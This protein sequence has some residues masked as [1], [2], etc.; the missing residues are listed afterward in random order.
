MQAF[1]RSI[2]HTV[3]H[4]LLILDAG[5]RVVVAN[6]SFYRTFGG[7][8]SLI[9]GC[10]LF[11]ID[12]GR[13]DHP[14]LRTLLVGVIPKDG[15]FR[16][17]EVEIDC[18]R[19]GRR[20]M[21]LDAHRVVRDEDGIPMVLLAIEDDTERRKA[22]DELYQL[23]TDLEHRIKT[24]EHKG[25]ELARFVETTR[26]QTLVESDRKIA[27]LE[28]KARDLADLVE[29]L[30]NQTQ[31]QSD[32][33]IALLVQK[34]RDLAVFV[35][36]VRN[37]TRSQAETEIA[38]LGQQAR[39]LAV[40]VEAVRELTLQHSDSQIAALGQSEKVTSRLNDELER[41]V[42]ERTR[43]LEAANRE[44]EAFCYSVSHDLRSPLRA[45]DG[46]SQELLQNYA[47]LLDEQGRHYLRRIRAGTQRM[48]QLID[49]LLRLSRVTRAEMRRDRVDLTTLAEA[50][51]AEMR[52][53]EP[54]RLVSLS[55]RPGL[56]AECDPQ[57]ICVVLENLL[58]NA[59][60]FT[61]KNPAAVIAFDRTDDADR[62]AF[63]VRDN[64][65]G[66]DMAFREKMFGV[67][68]RLHSDRDFPGTGIGLATVQRIVRRHGGDVWAEGAVGR[69]AAFYFTIP[70]SGEAT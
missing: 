60:K 22:R 10:D 49:D 44:L 53:R 4:P 28:Q 13:W 20:V 24:L 16:D 55:V 45:L 11:E 2:V 61:A 15:S 54:A 57:L 3:R 34:A 52:E 36:A 31:L 68:Q 37:E 70:G 69:G 42:L 27:A 62:P 64:G 46:F 38:A 8:S 47:D 30:R 9:D 56:T 39:D 51:V 21:V 33:K 65:A 26:Q 41:R 14:R 17:H 5:L 63:V 32:T 59:W 35:E 43:Q 29:G 58:A 6:A 1:A 40:S 25:R 23:N 18:P 7:T 19:L 12:G 48:G 66:F 67:F 50:V